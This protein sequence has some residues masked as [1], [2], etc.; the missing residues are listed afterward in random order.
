MAECKLVRISVPVGSGEQKRTVRSA[1]GAEISIVECPPVAAA[2]KS[3]LDQGWKVS[4][5]NVGSNSIVLFLT[6]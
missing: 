6:R 1:D 4:G 2:A 5:S 3:Y